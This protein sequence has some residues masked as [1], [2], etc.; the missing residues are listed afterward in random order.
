M[1]LV[2]LPSA[3]FS[4]GSTNTTLPIGDLDVANNAM[5]SGEVKSAFFDKK[6]YRMIPP[7]DTYMHT[8]RVIQG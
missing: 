7:I 3:F 2:V 6:S 1:D 8:D 4:S 5:V